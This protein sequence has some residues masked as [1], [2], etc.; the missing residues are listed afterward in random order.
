MQNTHE[1][2][3][4]LQSIHI[5]QDVGVTQG[6]HPLES[7]LGELGLLLCS[8]R[9]LVEKHRH[10]LSVGLRTQIGSNDTI[11]ALAIF[12]TWQY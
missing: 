9:E 11:V 6:L 4:H 7:S 2:N 10:R 12:R 5:S 1:P 8:L 3:T